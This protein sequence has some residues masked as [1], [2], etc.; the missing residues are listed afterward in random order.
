MKLT[1]LKTILEAT[2]FP[3]AYSHF[4][5]SQNEP[6]PVPPFVCYLV[7]YSTNF[8]AD[9][10]V[11]KSIQNVQIELYTNVKDIEAEEKLEALLNEHELPFETT[12]T[13]IDDE[14]LFQKIYEVRLL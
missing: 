7:T 8:M 6:L 3:V 13:Y 14:R 1:E 10:K 9:N 5:D 4:I 11:L 2:G 12:E